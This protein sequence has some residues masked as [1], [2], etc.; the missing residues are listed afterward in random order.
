MQRERDEEETLNEKKIVHKLT[1]F[2]HPAPELADVQRE[3]V[4][5]ERAD[6]V[7]LN[8]SLYLPPGYDCE[9]DGPL[10][11]FIWAYPREYKSAEFAGQMK[12]SPHR[13]V[14]LARTPLYWLTRGYA[15]L[16]GPE[17]PIIG[18]GDAEANDTYVE[19]LVS[20]AEA[21]VDMLVSKGI[22]E[23]GRMAIGGHSYGAF[24]TVNILAHAPHLFCCGIA[25]SGAYNR[26]LTP[27]GF[28]SEE[29][30]LWDA[31]QVYIQMSPYMFAQRIEAPLLLVHGDADNNP[32]TFPMQ[33]ERLYQALKGH[34]K[35]CRFVN[36]PHEGHGYRAR[37]S[38]MHVLAEMTVWLD[39]YC[40]GIDDN[41]MPEL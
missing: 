3:I 40:N 24:M 35:I 7:R 13:F 33:S 32:G 31:Q 27:F 10:P 23:R 39:K 2:P 36:L 17:M 6:G 11:V 37:E 18:E 5:Y 1:D 25:R 19:Q 20:S 28:Q 8:G 34:G 22:G 4:N 16:D 26:T 41:Y 15:I 30:T 9:K 38:V 29:R 21:A 12:G 14:R